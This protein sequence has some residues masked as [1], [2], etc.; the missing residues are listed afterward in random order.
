LNFRSKNGNILAA[1][2]DF[3][4]VRVFEYPARQAQAPSRE[5][6][7]GL[8]SEQIENDFIVDLP[9]FNLLTAVT[10]AT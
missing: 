10:Q 2:D 3:G 1:A 7:E 5:Y 9:G 4:H 8:K 6:R